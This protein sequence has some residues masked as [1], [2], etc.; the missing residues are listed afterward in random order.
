[1]N[2]SE[3][4]ALRLD[5]CGVDSKSEPSSL[6]QCLFVHSFCLFFFA[7]LKIL[8]MNEIGVYE[9]VIVCSDVLKVCYVFWMLQFVDVNLCAKQ[10][11][12]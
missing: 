2:L 11:K 3:D 9:C 5:F 12:L 10:E 7:L 6:P 1:M 8:E 4:Y